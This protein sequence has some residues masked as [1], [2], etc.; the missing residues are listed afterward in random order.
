[1]AFVT[2]PHNSTLPGRLAAPFR[3]IGDFLILLAEAGPRSEAFRRLSRMSD[4]ELA[5]RGTTRVAEIQ[6][7]VGVS[8][9]L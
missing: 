8:A 7:I 9:S 1:M 6:R 2:L 5:S 4:E 3:A